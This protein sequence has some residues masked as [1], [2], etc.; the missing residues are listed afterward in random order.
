MEF[1]QEQKV[2]DAIEVITW[3]KDEIGDLEAQVEDYATLE[4]EI[5]DLKEELDEKNRIIEGLEDEMKEWRKKVDHLEDDVEDLQR[6]L[7]KH[8]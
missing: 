4:K 8:Q 5:K 7:N 2:S 1:R 6:E 3:M